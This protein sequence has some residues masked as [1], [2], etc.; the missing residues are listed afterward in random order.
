[1]SDSISL[2]A[3]GEIRDALTAAARGDLPAAA[4]ALMSIDPASWQAMEHRLAAL[5][6]SLPDLVRAAQGEQAT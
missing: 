2:M 4:H 5:G 1:M 3:A 6:S